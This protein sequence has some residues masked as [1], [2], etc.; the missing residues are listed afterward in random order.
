MMQKLQKLLIYFQP[1]YIKLADITL[2]Y[3]KEANT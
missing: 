2:V 1:Q 3:K